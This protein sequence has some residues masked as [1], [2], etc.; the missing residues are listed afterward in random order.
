MQMVKLA[1]MHLEV[2]GATWMSAPQKDKRFPEFNRLL[3]TGEQ[4]MY[5]KLQLV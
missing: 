5:C 3:I 2:F 4:C 1:N